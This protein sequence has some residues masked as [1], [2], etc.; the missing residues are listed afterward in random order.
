MRTCNSGAGQGT[1]RSKSNFLPERWFRG[2]GSGSLY[3]EG[4]SREVLDPCGDVRGIRRI[5]A[6][7]RNNKAGQMH[8]VGIRAFALFLF[9]YNTIYPDNPSSL[10]KRPFPRYPP[11]NRRRRPRIRRWRLSPRPRTLRWSRLREPESLHR[12]PCYRRKT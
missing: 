6:R 8:R 10:H 3:G 11:H 2:L 7:E 5:E 4:R 1:G 9:R 12:P